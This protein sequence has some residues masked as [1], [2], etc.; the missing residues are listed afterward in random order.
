[1]CVNRLRKNKED[2]EKLIVDYYQNV[3]NKPYIK[4]IFNEW[5]QS[6]F[7]YSEISPQTRTRYENDFKRFFTDN[8]ISMMCMQKPE[9]SIS[10][11]AQDS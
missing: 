11:Y 1:M 6:K 9:Y 7:D 4:D 5:L 8:P 3:I 2:L 10:T